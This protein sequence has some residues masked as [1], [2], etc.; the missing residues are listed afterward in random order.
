MN[1]EISLLNYD[2]FAGNKVKPILK[3]SRKRFFPMTFKLTPKENWER[4][5]RFSAAEWIP[6]TIYIRDDGWQRHGWALND[7]FDRYFGTRPY[8]D[9]RQLPAPEPQYLDAAGNY[10]KVYTDEWGCVVEERI[11]GIMGMV[12][13]HPLA[14]WA[15]LKTF[16]TPP[17][18]DLSPES[19]SKA[20]SQ[21]AN[22]K[23]TSHV[24]QHFMHFFERM[25]WLRG[26]A[27]LM[28]DI[29]D[30]APELHE[31]ADLVVEHNLGWLKWSIAAGA[32]GVS[33]SDDWGTQKALMIRP[34]RWREFFKPCYRRMFQP[35]KSEGLLIYFHSD[36]YILDILPD[37][38]ELGVDI[39]NPQTNCHDLSELG[40]LCLDLGLCV[41]ADVDRQGVLAFGTPADVEGYFDRL[42]FELGN[43]S[44]GLI[45]NCECGADTPLANIEAAFRSIARYAKTPLNQLPKHR[46]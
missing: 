36:G 16:Q 23:M 10:H 24:F 34:E 15:A 31:L 12:L 14:D 6:H 25:Q 46:P 18:P 39:I 1:P 9:A 17:G 2:A 43:R 4:T 33:F 22:Q 7:L 42:A 30:D 20:R 11:F 27:D 45:F 13:K 35:L 29:A 38:R 37:L 5:V 44:G 3:T 19:I 28:A 32:D 26:Y 8:S 21:V 41:S 40:R